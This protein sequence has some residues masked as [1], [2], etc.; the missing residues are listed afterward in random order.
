MQICFGTDLLG[1]LGVFQSREFTLRSQVQSPLEILQSASVTPARRM[2][3]KDVGQ[4]EEGF[5]ANLLVVKSS[6]LD[7]ITVLASTDSE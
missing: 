4:I 2:G 7:D 6:L 1:P 5:L 3:L